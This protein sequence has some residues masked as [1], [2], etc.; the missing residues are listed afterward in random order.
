MKKTPLASAIG[1]IFA[2]GSMTPF[3]V[4]AQ[5][6]EE[7]E[8][9]ATPEDELEEVV[10]TG[11]RIKK[12]AF[13]T[14]QPMD[15]V[16]IREASVQGIANVG[17]LLQGN[18]TASGSPQVTA[19]TSFQFTQNGGLGANTIS[20]RGLGANRTLVLLNGRRAGPSG[21][22][23]GV[24][25]FDLNV[26]PLATIE[27]VEILKDGASSIYG[28]D[29][30]AGVVNIITRK[31]DG[32]TIDGF[33][34]QPSDSGGEESRLSLSYGKTFDRGNFR[35]TA[36]YSE[37]DHLRRGQRDYF[38]CGNQ[39]IFDINTGERADIVDP[40]T[41]ERWCED[42]TWGHVW[43]YDYAADSNVPGTGSLLSQPDYGDGLAQFIPGYAPPTNPGQ[44]TAPAN[45]FPVAY[46]ALTDG[47]TN[48][49]HPFQNQ[50]SLNPRVELLTFYAEGEFEFTD[51]LTGYTEFLFNRR[52]TESDGYRQYWSYVYSG[53]FDFSSLGTGTPGGGNS[54]A[55]A[56]GW[57]GEQWF[58]PTAIS[59]HNDESVEVD[60]TRVVAGLRGAFGD[61]ENWE[62]DL[63]FN[64]SNSDGT[65]T[66]DRIFN[67]SIRDQNWLSGS[68]V[69]TNTSVRGVPC[70]DVPWFD[71]DLLAGNISQELRG[72]LYG[73]ETGETEYTQWT[74]DGFVTGEAWDLPAGPLSI[75]AGF[76]YREDELKDTPGDITLSGNSWID[77]FA[78][79]TE[80]D[81]HTVA[82]FIEFDAPLIEDRPGVENLTLNASA[83]YTDVDSYGNDTT[84]KVGLNWQITDEFRLR[85]NRGT[86]FR[87]PALFELFIADQTG[88]IS[89][90]SDPCIRYEEEFQNG[91]LS[92]IVRDNCAADPR[93]L[94][95]DY[96]GGTITPTV[97]TGGGAGVLEAETA[98]STTIGLIWQPSFANL[99]VSIDYFKFEIDNEVDQLGGPQIIAG[100]YESEF[101][102][103]FGGTEPLCDLFDRTSINFG[104]DNVRD[105]FIN[106]ANQENSG[107]DFALRYQTEIGSGDLTVDVKTTKQEDDIRAIFQETSE[108]LN[109]RVGDPEWV[110]ETK[111]TYDMG[112]WSFFWGMD[113]VGSSDSTEQYIENQGQVEVTY[114]GVDYRGVFSTDNVFY[115]AFSASYDFDNGITLL[116]GVA[117]AFDENPPQLTRQGVSTDIY[118]MIGNSVLFSNYDMLGRR[119]FVNATYLFE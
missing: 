48:D 14:S 46:D 79:V 29:A 104:I 1:S 18:T 89:Q 42:L 5:E 85:A 10:V 25:A 72:F 11:S 110:G 100:C 70:I 22:Q 34:S 43:I 99:S 35:V 118:T 117:N 59:D 107:F 86:S 69:G 6:E 116:G 105:S 9:F 80:G 119:F 24:S 41:G 83:R 87:S 88:T 112:P 39:F 111:V 66:N 81:D 37:R 56:A 62:W 90:R 26:L 8:R 19:A 16:D 36:D 27:R 74:V 108:D 4:F 71:P 28:S 115:H 75:A 7:Q 95:P 55:A 20:L 109:G 58:S 113:W 67:D 30:V 91:N 114:R 54:L 103:A 15:I 106:I 33:V 97:L 13:T 96:S 94:P 23:G 64:Y 60:Y 44:L 50:E 78:G 49:D 45:F 73:V 38:T 77:D 17:D 82:Y 21:V 2:V 51:T 65:Y 57:F 3:V 32:G 12:D 68:C 52:E 92:Q 53:N 40:R 31:D 47:I 98:D 101:G 61:N 76:Q 93:N 63:G 84:W 102:F